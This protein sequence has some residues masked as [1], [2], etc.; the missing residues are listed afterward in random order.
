MR[1][2][3]GHKAATRARIVAVAAARFRRD[4]VAATGIAPI[5][6]EAGLT[7]GGFYAHFE[8]KEALVRESLDAALA[9]TRRRQEKAGEAGLRGRLAHYL[10]AAHRD[11]PAQGCAVA[12]LVAEIARHPEATRALL[13]ARLEA[14]FARYESQLPEAVP[15]AARRGRAIAIFALLLGAL[16]LARAATDAALSDKI[17]QSGIEAAQSLAATAD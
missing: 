11:A 13:T 2:D 3:K 17:L 6:E 12:A 5:M 4:G 1:F 15:Q 8:S 16:Q 7:H 10:S 14:I 9:Q